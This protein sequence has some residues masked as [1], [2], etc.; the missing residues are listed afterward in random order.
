MT[1]RP[2]EVSPDPG[3]RRG[4]RAAAAGLLPI[5]LLLLTI[6]LLR[7][8]LPADQAVYEPPLLLLV[9]NTLFVFVCACV[10]AFIAGRSYL[11]TGSPRH[12]QPPARVATSAV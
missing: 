9:L 5:G 6:L 1:T 2:V 10:V 8:L 3:G 12:E 4:P 11:L 7:L